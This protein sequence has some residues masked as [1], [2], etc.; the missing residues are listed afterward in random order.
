MSIKARRTADTITSAGSS[1]GRGHY[2]SGAPTPTAID[3]GTVYVTNQ[4]VIFQGSK[5]T[6]ECKFAKLLGVQH[7][8]VEGSTTLSVSNRQ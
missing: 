6:R 4:R 5:Q 7:D 8:D 3:N 2:V 1:R